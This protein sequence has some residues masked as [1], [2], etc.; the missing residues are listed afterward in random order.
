[1]V[2]CVVLNLVIYVSLGDQPRFVT[3]PMDQ[4]PELKSPAG[5]ILS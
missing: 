4:E 5:F 3:T 2:A 1:M